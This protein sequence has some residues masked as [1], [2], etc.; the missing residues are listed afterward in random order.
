[1]SN[2]HHG[3]QT[4]GWKSHS[5]M[6]KQILAGNLLGPITQPLL[7]CQSHFEFKDWAYISQYHVKHDDIF[8]PIRP[9]KTTIF[10]APQPEWKYL[11]LLVNQKH[12]IHD[13]E[14]QQTLAK[15]DK[16]L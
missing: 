4:T 3:Q 8:E 10:D 15:P 2:I 9:G 11:A 6:A 16:T 1:M 7:I 13:K 12:S 5:K 14:G